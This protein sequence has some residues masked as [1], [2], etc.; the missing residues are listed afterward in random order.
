MRIR[1]VKPPSLAVHL[2][3]IVMIGSLM[4][5]TAIA[6]TWISTTALVVG[7][8]L[9]GPRV[10][11]PLWL[12]GS[13]RP[14]QLAV[15]G[16]ACVVMARFLSTRRVRGL[17][18]SLTM[19]GAGAWASLLWVCFVSDTLLF[20]LRNPSV[21]FFIIRL[22]L[23]MIGCSIFA[24]FVGVAGAL[25]KG[26]TT[27]SGVRVVYQNGFL[28][29][30]CGY[31][32][33]VRVNHPDAT[34]SECGVHHRLPIVMGRS[35]LE[36]VLPFCATSCLALALCAVSIGKALAAWMPAVSNASAVSIKTIPGSD[37]VLGGAYMK[38]ATGPTGA[39]QL[40]DTLRAALHVIPSRSRQD[41]VF[42]L[43][44]PFVPPETSGVVGQIQIQTTSSNVVGVDWGSDVLLYELSEAELATILESGISPALEDLLLDA[45]RI[46]GWTPNRTVPGQFGRFIKI[47]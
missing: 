11:S 22:I 28:C 33:T 1:V 46:H 6:A 7:L 18:V 5:F 12:M 38:M 24:V 15:S 32:L 40:D 30:A 17:E 13:G 14:L 41:V 21:G 20:S 26:A 8:A 39:W 45:V 31:P 34:C 3:S 36:D 16:V 19:L 10:V 29:T 25:V 27:A 4:F 47:R 35:T 42:V 37:S 43:A 9:S 44:R 23:S 2:R